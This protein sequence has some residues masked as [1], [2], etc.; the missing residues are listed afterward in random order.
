M[1]WSVISEL[2]TNF[3]HDKN[4]HVKICHVN[5]VRPAE[6]GPG[7]S[8]CPMPRASGGL[9]A[10]PSA[11]ACTAC[12]MTDAGAA[13]VEAT[14]ALATYWYLVVQAFLDKIDWTCKWDGVNVVETVNF[15]KTPCF[16][17]FYQAIPGNWAILCCLICAMAFLPCT[18]KACAN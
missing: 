11:R 6:R 12:W 15:I 16:T 13:R 14:S 5:H 7:S 10:P 3:N 17:V 1:C 4:Q 9:P 2:R 18:L 8:A